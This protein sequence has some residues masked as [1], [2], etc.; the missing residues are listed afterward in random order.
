MKH[1]MITYDGLGNRYQIIPGVF[2]VPTM[3]SVVRE[4]KSGRHWGPIDDQCLTSNNCDQID[5][6]NW[7]VRAVKTAAR[8]ETDFLRHSF[9]KKC[10]YMSDDMSIWQHLPFRRLF[11]RWTRII[12]LTRWRS[13][14][15]FVLLFIFV[16][17]FYT[18][19]CLSKAEIVKL[20]PNGFRSQ[21]YFSVCFQFFPP[22]VSA[23]SLGNTTTLFW[24]CLWI[25][26]VFSQITRTV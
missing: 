7:T 8:A 6:P 20:S 24:M 25:I 1:P 12:S 17:H 26:C 4:I 16:T 13:R 19:K 5:N 23:P 15:P 14:P 3:M 22:G 11:S 18:I 21:T 10:E 2:P 9:V